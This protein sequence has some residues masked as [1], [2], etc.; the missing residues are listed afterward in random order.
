M[1]HLQALRQR[2]PATLAT[3]LRQ[4]VGADGDFLRALYTARRWDEV[5]AAPGWNDVQRLAFLHSQAE[6]QQQ[7]YARHYPQA[8]FFILEQ[9]GQPVGRLCLLLESDEARIIDIALLP[10][11]Q[12]QGLGS[13][14]LL[15][16]LAL[17]DARGQACGLSVDLINPA[18]RLYARLGFTSV[19]QQGL[20]LQM[21]RAAEHCATTATATQ[22]M[23]G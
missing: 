4:Q 12:G 14:L 19:G 18:Q 1:S 7:H 8:D 6:L 17:T 23:D 21:R 9:Q 2:L 13:A 10:G 15:A 3:D 11:W 20:Y 22:L 16:V 5:S